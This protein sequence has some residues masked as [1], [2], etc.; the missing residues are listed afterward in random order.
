MASDYHIRYLDTNRLVVGKSMNMPD[1]LKK[2]ENAV[3]VVASMIMQLSVGF[4]PKD[5]LT[6]LA[7]VAAAI[8]HERYK[9]SERQSQVRKFAADMKKF[10]L[11]QGQKLK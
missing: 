8:V 9:P 6:A 10:I 4:M 11:Q 7:L 3:R 2:R 5:F 1:D